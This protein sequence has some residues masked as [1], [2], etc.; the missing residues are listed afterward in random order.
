[1]NAKEFV[2]KC[3]SDIVF[4]IEHVLLDEEGAHHTV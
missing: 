1:M 2:L 3:R 4:F